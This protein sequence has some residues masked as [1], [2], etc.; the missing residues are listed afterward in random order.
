MCRSLGLGATTQVAVLEQNATSETI[1][2]LQCRTARAAL[3][4]SPR[5]LGAETGISVTELRPFE[6]GKASLAPSRLILLRSVFEAEGVIF[7]FERGEGT[8]IRLAIEV[9]CSL[10]A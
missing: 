5:K 10:R 3:N 9:A 2:A 6:S 7:L 4:W 1:S 8:G